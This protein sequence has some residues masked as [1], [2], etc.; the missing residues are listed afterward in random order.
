MK[1]IGC[2]LL[3]AVIC[4]GLLAGCESADAKVTSHS[5]TKPTQLIPITSFT[6]PSTETVPSVGD[7][8]LDGPFDGLS[9]FLDSENFVP[10]VSQSDFCDQLEKYR[11]D[12]KT[13]LELAIGYHYDSPDGGGYAGR[14]NQLDYRND[15]EV[16]EDQQHANY[17]NYF[18]TVVPLEGMS[19]PYGI[20]FTDTVYDALE[21]MNL[22]IDPHKDFV[23]DEGSDICMTLFQNGGTKLTLLDMGREKSPVEYLMRYILVYT[24]E[25]T[26]QRADGRIATVTRKL[27]LAFS[28]DEDT[29]YWVSLYVNEYFKRG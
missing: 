13:V 23:A 19:L 5:N 22:T 11:Y 1:K 6:T 15:Y 3:I 29:L 17:N 26:V 14:N 21:K 20:V 24:E 16:T 28:M 25:Y 9:A 12:G 7:P 2:L 18:K 4:L 8:N 10:G 27:E